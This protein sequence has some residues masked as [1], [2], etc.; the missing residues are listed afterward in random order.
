MA[1]CNKGQLRLLK[2]S[3]DSPKL[4]ERETANP[5]PFVIKKI[6]DITRNEWHFLTCQ[7]KL[8]T[9]FLEN[10]HFIGDSVLIIYFLRLS[11]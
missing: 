7:R 6:F 5:D 4:W 1:A 3:M 9:E 2:Y 11:A 10:K 8:S